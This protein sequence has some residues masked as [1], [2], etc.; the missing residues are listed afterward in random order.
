MARQ[1]HVKKKVISMLLA[2]ALGATMLAGCTSGGKEAADKG[3]EDG[4]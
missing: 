2:A 1:R 4:G 3:K